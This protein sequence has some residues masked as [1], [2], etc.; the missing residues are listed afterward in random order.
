LGKFLS[1]P[2]L[3]FWI[4][5]AVFL[6]LSFSLPIVNLP[7]TVDG[8]TIFALEVMHVI[9]AAAIVGVLTFLGREK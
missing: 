5:S 6:A 3:A 9:A 1:R 8:P 2:I 4:I 7:A